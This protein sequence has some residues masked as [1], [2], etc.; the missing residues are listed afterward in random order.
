VTAL[1]AYLIVACGVDLFHTEDY[2]LTTG[3]TAA[4]SESC[5]ACKFLAGAN[6]TQAL[7]ETGPAGLEY[8]V[9]SAP[10]PQTSVI[11]ARPWAKSILL[12]A[13][14]IPQS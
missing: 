4:A 14:P 3:K 13:P 12:R 1:V 10:T 9:V 7:Y 2:P 11:V 6:S 8:L 5:P